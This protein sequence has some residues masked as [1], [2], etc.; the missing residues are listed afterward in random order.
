MVDGVVS[1]K[2]SVAKLIGKE[3]DVIFYPELK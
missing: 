2:H 1:D 3:L